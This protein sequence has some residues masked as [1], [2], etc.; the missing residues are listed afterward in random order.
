M[1]I[2][3]KDSLLL[4]AEGGNTEQNSTSTEEIEIT[5]NTATPIQMDE[6]ELTVEEK[7]SSELID[8]GDRIFFDYD[9]ASLDS[10]AKILLDAQSRFLRV[11]TD[12]NIIIEGHCDERGTREY[13]LASRRKK[14]F[15]RK[16]LFNITRY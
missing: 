4:N 1:L 6:V 12:L 3:T 5:D 2:K 8:V 14:S 10:S 9:S 13:N 16:E 15:S 7:L 11:N